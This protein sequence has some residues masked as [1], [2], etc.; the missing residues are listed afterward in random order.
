MDGT[1]LRM[2]TNHQLLVEGV[3]VDLLVLYQGDE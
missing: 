2:A 1:L 3:A